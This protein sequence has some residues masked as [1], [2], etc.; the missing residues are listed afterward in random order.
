MNVESSFLF[1][2]DIDGTLIKSDG[3][4]SGAVRRAFKEYF[5]K[6]PNT[7]NFIFDGKT[8]PLIFEQLAEIAGIPS[9][10]F[11]EHREIF[12]E[13]VYEHMGVT[14]KERKIRVINQIVEILKLL[15]KNEN[16]F[17]G[18][19][20][21]NDIRGAY[22]KL[23]AVGLKKWFRV[24][25]YGSDDKNRNLLPP[26]AV[27]RAERLFETSFIPG[28]IWVVGDTPNDVIAGKRN[29][30]STLAVSTGRYSIDELKRERPDI[31]ANSLNPGI[32]RKIIE[33]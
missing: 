25:A 17:V 15:E 22:H 31:A 2:F 33:G 7:E 13:L 21:G 6:T 12:E 28:N 16:V 4:G 14:V 18:L 29:H 5:G 1:L 3:A 11:A 30:F 20:T 10:L 26:I 19:V 8:D 32:F 27:H 9:S 24:G 23:N